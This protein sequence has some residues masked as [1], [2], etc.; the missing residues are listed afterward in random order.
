MAYQRENFELDNYQYQKDKAEE[1]ALKESLGVTQLENTAYARLVTDYI[2]CSTL[3]VNSFVYP[4]VL[5][6]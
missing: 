2:R 3:Y 5:E 4:A 1:S 6:Q